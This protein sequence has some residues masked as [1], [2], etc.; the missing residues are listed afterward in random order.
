MAGGGGRGGSIAAVAVLFVALLLAFSAQA[1]AE[2]TLPAAVRSAAAT[3]RADD[4]RVDRALSAIGASSAATAVARVGGREALVRRQLLPPARRARAHARAGARR[5]RAL[6]AGEGRPGA[7]RRIAITALGRRDE[8]FLGAGRAL[9]AAVRAI[10]GVPRA[11][12]AGGRELARRARRADRLLAAG[13]RGLDR[14]VAALE[15]HGAPTDAAGDPGGAAQTAPSAAGPAPGE[16]GAGSPVPAGSPDAGAVIATEPPAPDACPAPPYAPDDVQAGQRYRTRGYV[17]V[18]FENPYWPWSWKTPVALDPP[19]R[20]VDEDGVFQEIRDG[21][22]YDHPM[23]QAWYAI[24]LLNGYWRTGDQ[25]YLDRARAN[26]ERVIG[27]AV[28]YAGADF[29]P[30]PFD[31]ALHGDPSDVMTAP[32]YSAIAQGRVLAALVRMHHFTREDRYGALADRA[33]RSFLVPHGP[34]HPWVTWIDDHGL[35]WLEEY[36]KEPPMA[37]LNGHITAALGVREYY[38]HV[39]DPVLKAQALRVFDGAV[40]TVRERVMEFRRP[41]GPSVYGLRRCYPTTAYHPLHVE[42][43]GWLNRF[44][45]DRY[46]S[47]AA[48]VLASDWQPPAP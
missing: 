31:F 42:Q 25:R 47:D 44:T 23:F 21:R 5:L 20:P 6:P 43:L 34:G 26:V 2:G 45:E 14:A 15:A 4:R 18:A 28:P 39:A 35:L 3:A 1:A 7:A 46:F 29:Y 19:D 10:P 22:T 24:L 8:A 13:R 41:G 30:Y 27:Q 9:T 40:S 37:V 32:W 33:F 38:E 16:E 36:P 11:R 48:A 17:P 12:G